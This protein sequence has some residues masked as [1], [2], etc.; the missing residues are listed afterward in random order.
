MI[1]T[2]LWQP[3][4]I[5]QGQCLE[6][7]AGPLDIWLRRKGDELHIAVVRRTASKYLNRSAAPRTTAGDEPAGLDWSRW[8]CGP[9]CE[10]VL[11]VPVTPDRPVVVRPELPVKI[12]PGREALFFVGIPMWVRIMAGD[13]QMVQLCEQPA[14]ILSNIWFGDPTSGD[15]CYSLRTRA[16]RDI[17]NWQTEP[18]RAVCPVTISNS[19]NTQLDVERLCVHAVHLSVFPGA[20]RLWTNRVRITFKGKGEVSQLEYAEKPPDYEEVGDVLS[21]PRR[22]VKKTLL[23]RSLGGFG[24]FSGA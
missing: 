4:H 7:Q 14:V 9:D 1:D 15:L 10:Q 22:S 20:S 17:S 12:P 24:L 6:A 3:H 16:R 18:H 21:K 8:V 11:L 19:A 2:A 23:K 13:A 5:E